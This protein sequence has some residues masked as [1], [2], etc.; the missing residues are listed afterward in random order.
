MPPQTGQPPQMPPQGPQMPQGQPQAIPQQAPQPKQ[1]TNPNFNPNLFN[2]PI[3]GQ[4]MTQPLGAAKWQQPPQFVHLDEFLEYMWN[5]MLQKDMT[6]HIYGMLSIGVPCEAIARTLL[7]GCFAHGIC[8]VTLANLAVRTVI[9]QIGAIGHFLGVKN[10]KVRNHDA[11]KVKQLAD[12]KKLMDEFD[13][14]DNQGS[15]QPSAP[16]SSGSQIFSGLGG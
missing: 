5:K 10:I 13:N 14:D 16:A 15:A 4:G 8:T 11:K 12:L 1:Q 9:R 7:F 6:M 2:G 3:P